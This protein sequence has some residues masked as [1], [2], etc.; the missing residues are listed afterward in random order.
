MIMLICFAAFQARRDM[1]DLL[2]LF[3]LGILGIFLRRFGWPRPAF[4]IGFVLSGQVEAYLYQA[5]QFNGWG[6][7]TRPGVLI[8]GALAIAS[9]LMAVCSRVSEDGSVA[10]GAQAA[11]QA[12][13]APIGGNSR[14]ERMPQIV[15]SVLLLI[16]FGYG[17]ASS[18]PLSFLGAVFPLATSA[19]MLIF[20]GIIVWKQ[21]HAAPG[22]S[23]HY[24]QEVAAKIK[25]EH[26]GKSVWPS[27]MWFAFLFGLTTLAGFI[28]S[29]A[30]FI[31]TFLMARTSLGWPRSLLYAAVCIAF[32]S[33]V[34]HFM[35]LDFPAGLLQR[36]VELPWPLK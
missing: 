7:V 27:V 9:L 25:G 20:T 29:L 8:I 18:Y 5:V 21:L 16:V 28:L 19:L 33:T 17:V 22:H 24:D 3:G 10:V 31:I 6:F 30:V 1:T 26:D 34:G 23:T 14:A 4:L 2:L 15:F 13:A 11:E 32:M 35:T 36:M 12:A